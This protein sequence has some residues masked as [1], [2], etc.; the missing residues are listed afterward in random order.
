M[1]RLYRVSRARFLAKIQSKNIEFSKR[2]KYAAIM[3]FEIQFMPVVSRRLCL[4][5]LIIS[6]DDWFIYGSQI[7]ISLWINSDSEKNKV[8]QIILARWSRKIQ[9]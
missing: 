5:A 1:M 2:R 9:V 8:N 7:W 3:F 6:Y 4:C